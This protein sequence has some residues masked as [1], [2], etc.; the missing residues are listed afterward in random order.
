MLNYK[1][2][3]DD[4]NNAAMDVMAFNDDYQD[5]PFVGCFWYDPDRNE[6]YGVGKT[7]AMDVEYYDSMQWKKTIKT[8]RL[9]HKN[10]WQKE[11]YRKRDKRF[12]GDYTQKPRGIVFEFK[13]EGFKV[14]TGSWI[15]DYPKAKEEIIFG[16]Q[17][18]EN[19]EFIIDEHRQLGHGWSNEF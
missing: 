18:P 6:L 2:R 17:L 13:D 4:K 8:G 14:F 3:D 1:K 12:S 11:Y 10:I 19:T 5:E 16:F 7:M 15:N 9:L